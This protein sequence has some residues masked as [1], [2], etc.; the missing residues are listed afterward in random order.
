MKITYPCELVF[1]D[2]DITKIAEMCGKAVSTVSYWSKSTGPRLLKNHELFLNAYIQINAS[3]FEEEKRLRE[4]Y[5]FI[6]DSNS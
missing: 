4:L 5:A 3:I 2:G 1:K 6:G